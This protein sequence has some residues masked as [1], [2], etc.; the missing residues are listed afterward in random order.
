MYVCI[1]VYIYIYIYVYIVVYIYIYTYTHAHEHIYIYIYIYSYIYI[2][3]EREMYIY[4]YIHTCTLLGKVPGKSTQAKVWPPEQSTQT[5]SFHVYFQTASGNIAW[6][7]NPCLNIVW[8]THKRPILHLFAGTLHTWWWWKPLNVRSNLWNG[9][10]W[11]L[12]GETHVTRFPLIYIY[13]YI[14]MIT[15]AYVSQPGA[16]NAGRIQLYICTHMYNIY[17]YIYTYI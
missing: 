9:V 10:E 14:C 4:I 5:L 7:Y 11:R 6:V 16:R 15:N 8:Q 13:I 12:V 3:R 2:E 17:I 1:Y